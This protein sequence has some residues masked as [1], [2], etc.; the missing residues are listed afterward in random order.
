M[1]AEEV[2]DSILWAAGDLDRKMG[3]PE[4]PHEQGLTVHRRSLYFAHHGESKMEFL[5]LFDEANPS[6][7]YRRT[8]SVLPQQALALS[9]SELTL[10]QGRLLAHKLQIQAEGKPEAAGEFIQAAFEQ[11]LGRVPTSAEREAAERF[12]SRQALLFRD[13]KLSPSGAD[14]P[15]HDPGMRALENLVIA[16]FN[17]NDFITIR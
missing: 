17:H 11:L 10:R 15:A 6:E 9:N 14:G 3:G 8:T 13:E 4:I 16:L 1:D 2:R 12:L 7:C 5:E